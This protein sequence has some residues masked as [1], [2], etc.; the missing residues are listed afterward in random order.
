MVPVFGDPS[1]DGEA[2]VRHHSADGVSYVL[3][4]T[5]IVCGSSVE[6]ESTEKDPMGVTGTQGKPGTD[7]SLSSLADPLRLASH[8]HPPRV[9]KAGS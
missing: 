3:L 1:G 2:K 5:I 9:R 4:R 7:N 6:G 8:V